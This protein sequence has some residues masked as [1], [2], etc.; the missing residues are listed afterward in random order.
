MKSNWMMKLGRKE[1]LLL[2]AS[3]VAILSV[4]PAAA[5]DITIVST[6]V[7]SS[8]TDTDLIFQAADGTLTLNDGGSIGGVVTTTTASGS[9]IIFSGSGTMVGVIGNATTL[10][11]LTA[12]VATNN[13][14]FDAGVA[15]TTLLIT[16]LGSVTFSDTA[17][18][19][20]NIVGSATNGEVIFT[21]SSTIGGTVGETSS[22]ITSITAGAAAST[23]QFDGDVIANQILMTS[24]GMV[25]FA[26]GVDLTGAVVQTASGSNGDLLFIGATTVTGDIGASG[27]TLSSILAGVTGTTSQFDGDVYA[28]VVQLS[29][30]GT[31]TF[32][33]A[34]SLTGTITA[35]VDGNSGVVFSGDS[36]VTG[37][38]G[39]PGTTI[40]TLH[41][42]VAS[43]NV[44]F[45]ANIHAG[46]VALTAAG[47]VTFMDGVSVGGAIEAV[48]NGSGE[49]KFA[50]DST[51]SGLV[52][53]SGTTLSTITAGAASKNVQFDANIHATAIELTSTGSVT[54]GD[55]VSV[56]GIVESSSVSQGELVFGGSG[57][58][59]STVGA[60]SALSTITA[61]VAGSTAQFDSDVTAAQIKMTSTGMVQFSAGADLTGAVV[62]T[63]SGSNGDLLFIGA[64]TVTGDIGASGSTLSSILAGVTGTTSQFDGDV[65]AGVVQLSADGTVTFSDAKSLTGT[66]TALVDAN[67]GVVFSGD[68]TVTGVVGTSGTT[69]GT[70]HAGVASKS[71]QFDANVHATVVALT[72]AGSVTFSDGASL[73]GAVEAVVNGSGE[74]MFTGDSTV[75]GLVGLSGT[76]LSTITA[77][78][79]S[80]NVQFDANIHTTTILLTSSGS[81]TF[82]DGTSHVGIIE[83]A[84]MSQGEL[85]FTGSGTLAST[86]GAGSS[87]STIKAGAAGGVVQFLSDTV[88][89]QI[90]LTSSGTVSFGAGASLSGAI[91]MTGTDSTGE[92][93][94]GGS[95]TISG[96]VGAS[97][98]TLASIRAGVADTTVQFDSD[99][100]AQTFIMTATGTVVMSTGT[101]ISGSIVSD[102]ASASAGELTFTGD[103]TL[104]GNLGSTVSSLFSVSVGAASTTSQFDGTTIYSEAFGMSTGTTTFTNSAT[105]AGAIVVADGGT[106][107][108]GSK[109]ITNS[110]AV[111]GAAGTVDLGGTGTT[112]KI[113]IVDNTNFGQISATTTFNARNAAVTVDLGSAT[114]YVANGQ[115]FKIFESAGASMSNGNV[116]VTTT[117]SAV[118][119]FTSSAASGA[120]VTLTAARNAGGYAGAATGTSSSALTGLST[121][122]GNLGT[123]ATGSMATMLGKLDAM[124][125]SD[126]GQTLSQLAP[127]SMN[128]AT[129][130]AA[131]QVTT[132][133]S[134][135][136]NARVAMLQGHQ[137]ASAEGVGFEPASGVSAGSGAKRH[138]AWVQV[139]G[140]FGDQ[141]TR[142][143]VDGFE[144]TTYGMALGVDTAVTEKARVGLAFSYANTTIDDKGARAG[145]S[146]DV[147]SY[148]VNLYGTYDIT[149]AWYVDGGATFGVHQYDTT[150]KSALL[151]ATATGDFSGYQYGVNTRV[152]YKVPLNKGKMLLTPF[153][154]MDYTRLDQD[155]Y[156]ETGTGGLPLKVNAQ[157]FDS[158]KIGG[159]ARLS[160]EIKRET[161][162]L[163]PE[164]HGGVFYDTLA[165]KTHTTAAFTGGGSSFTVDNVEPAKTSFNAGLGL[166]VVTA[167]DLTVT[168][169][170]DA[171][172]KEDFAGH[173]GAMKVRMPF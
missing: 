43:K 37:V 31:V 54:F 42:G 112:V 29:A 73:V 25:K 128:G 146:T 5:A 67:S 136:V 158:F 115:T 40:G 109:T 47:S 28:G 102:G 38:V 75:T 159:G 83:S 19:S 100:S 50:G 117:N 7:V 48:V 11:T 57:T 9:D 70:L 91:A 55:G 164:V 106:L 119:S 90:L 149:T 131:S 60:G 108:I 123:S 80:K 155:G 99:V 30:D 63:A 169:T 166:S 129:T 1:A 133:V 160:G 165:G 15:A 26:N 10:G 125:A 156:T 113:K 147:N 152:G 35:L 64:T 111:G 8:G 12:G 53:L 93:N 144:S 82:S 65:Y 6:N 84:S 74:L 139:L 140:S 77:G 151:S 142:K 81:V 127:P 161:V 18:L 51:V 3:A 59:A 4:K 110:A 34:K 36:T 78:A 23:V 27:S 143:N 79:A 118:L 172:L 167:S 95:S 104:A 49:A 98:S 162:R 170:Y 153:A 150:R 86:V 114:G 58:L 94:F 16:N 120:D 21:G 2:G 92:L 87:L 62:Q 41:A 69:I 76:T 103:G 20:G 39:T 137:V 97:G 163:L 52:G 171:D 66:I 173:T 154:S 32:S 22:G 72:A 17:S 157:S 24:T 126:L 44:Q 33:D 145:N 130:A 121:A 105:V 134:N 107:D 141:G 68:S 14:Q 116:V 88:A 122:L 124:T 71:V 135:V 168:V 85:V 138:G 46:V 45:D 61:G 13:V 96:T 148:L 89:T 101:S 56:V 132:A